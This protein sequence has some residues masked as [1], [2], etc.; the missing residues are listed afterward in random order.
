[1]FVQTLARGT[2][3]L[4]SCGLAAL[5]QTEKEKFMYQAEVIGLS[6]RVAKRGAQRDNV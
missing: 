5:L 6:G 3:L 1:M 4:P 2:G